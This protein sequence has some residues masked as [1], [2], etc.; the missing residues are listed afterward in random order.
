[1]PASSTWENA[2]DAAQP[3]L[4][5]LRQSLH[6]SLPE[7]VSI[8]RVGQFDAEILDQELISVLQEPLNKALVLANVNSFLGCYSPYPNHF[9]GFV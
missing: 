9:K 8:S 2:W 3:R 1:M 4:N 5:A 6:L 7:N